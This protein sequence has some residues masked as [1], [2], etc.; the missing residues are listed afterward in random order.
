MDDVLVYIISM[1]SEEDPDSEERV[2][3]ICEAGKPDDAIIWFAA[4]R[5]AEL[6]KNLI[7]AAEIIKGE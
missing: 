4:E 5:A 6:G 3:A 1:E 2:V 7:E